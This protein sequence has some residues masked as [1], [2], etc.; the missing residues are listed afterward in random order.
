MGKRDKQGAE[1]KKKETKT[2]TERD[3]QNGGDG[4][5]NIVQANKEM[6]FNALQY[7]NI[8]LFEGALTHVSCH[9]IWCIQFFFR[10]AVNVN[11]ENRRDAG[12]T[13]EKKA[14]KKRK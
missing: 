5:N 7:Y 12:V 6:I 1:K 13:S 10:L 11:W 9:F 14:K 8:G 3:L 2:E 4:R